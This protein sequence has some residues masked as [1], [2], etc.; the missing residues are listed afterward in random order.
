[1]KLK[2]FRSKLTQIRTSYIQLRDKKII[3]MASLTP[4]RILFAREA[5]P[6]Q[7]PS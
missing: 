4:Q 7:S 2:T 5:R 3:L 6:K 1:M